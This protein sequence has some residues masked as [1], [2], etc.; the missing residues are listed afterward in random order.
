MIRTHLD[1]KIFNRRLWKGRRQGAFDQDALMIP[2]F[3]R[4]RN[5]ASSTLFPFDMITEEQSN[6][7]SSEDSSCIG[8]LTSFTNAGFFD[9]L[10]KTVNQDKDLVFITDCPAWKTQYLGKATKLPLN[11]PT[12]T[13]CNF[14]NRRNTS[15]SCKA[16]E[17]FSRIFLFA[18][19]MVCTPWE[20]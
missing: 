10:I 6:Q 19:A 1:R 11:S 9:H 17:F 18:R 14:R 15:S 20:I 12:S 4:P 7:V 16:V 8:T 2:F 5:V 3:P 13:S